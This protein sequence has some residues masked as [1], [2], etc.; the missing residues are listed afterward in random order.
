M[1]PNT[2]HAVPAGDARDGL[3]AGS[4]TSPSD[5]DKSLFRL[6]DAY[7]LMSEKGHNS[8][9][10]RAAEQVRIDFISST[11]TVMDLPPPVVGHRSQSAPPTASQKLTLEELE[12]AFS[13]I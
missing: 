11:V 8:V 5:T 2:Y 12:E 10:L 1:S 3:K 13:W 6:S 9:S 7:E 4:D